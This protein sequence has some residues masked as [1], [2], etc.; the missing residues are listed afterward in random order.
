MS[1][2]PLYPRG[3]AFR[4]KVMVGNRQEDV[5]KEEELADKRLLAAVV[6]SLDMKVC[7]THLDFIDLSQSQRCCFA[8]DLLLRALRF[9]I[10]LDTASPVILPSSIST[11]EFD[12][13]HSS[14]TV[15]CATVL[16]SHSFLSALPRE[17]ATTTL[18]Y[19]PH[20]PSPPSLTTT[21]SLITTAPPSP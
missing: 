17:N 2:T 18:N 20:S 14:I 8:F 4:P 10:S 21:R 7:L 15:L 19:L 6:A 16:H 12:S 11:A 1:L 13:L 3:L 9:E 5:K